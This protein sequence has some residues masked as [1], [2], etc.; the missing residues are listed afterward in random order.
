MFIKGKKIH[1]DDVSILNIYTPNAKAST[2]AK[3]TLLNLKSNVKPHI[4][5]VGDFNTPI[6]LVDRSS[7]KKLN[8]EI[9]ELTNVMTQ[10]D[11]N[12][13]TKYISPKH[14]RISFFF[15]ITSWNLS[16]LSIF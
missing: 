16:N 5:M 6:S 2:V 11:L 15:L 12:I 3:E 4:L 1:Q 7:R 13:F 9:I 14:K 10:I 8:R